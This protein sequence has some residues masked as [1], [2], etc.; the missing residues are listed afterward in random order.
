MRAAA[1]ALLCAVAL[2]ACSERGSPTRG[3]APRLTTV[4]GTLVARPPNPLPP[5]GRAV[6]ELRDT[7]NADGPVVAEASIPLRGAQPPIRFTLDVDPARLRADGTYTV[8][9]VVEVNG[10]PAW[11]GDAVPVDPMTESIDLGELPIRGRVALA[12]ATTL[13]CG[14]R[15]EVSF[16]VLDDAVHVV[17]DDESIP[18][19]PVAGAP[20]GHYE[21]A[22]DR[23]TTFT[24]TGDRARLVVRGDAWPECVPVK[25]P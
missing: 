7:A 15:G 19:R 20:S 6:V 4:Q 9:G 1:L 16:G 21:A 2:P 10:Q 14:D 24:V 5:D 13:R 25:R 17:T 12:S 3:A 23:S 18:L 8:R 22:N 11:V